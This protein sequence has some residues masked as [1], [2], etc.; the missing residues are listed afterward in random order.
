MEKDGT[1]PHGAA[2]GKR[3][4]STESESCHGKDTIVIG[5]NVA[6]HL[7]PNARTPRARRNLESV[8]AGNTDGHI[9]T[10]HLSS[11]VLRKIPHQGFSSGSV[12][13]TEC[14]FRGSPTKLHFTPPS[15][16]SPGVPVLIS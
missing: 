6:G 11:I 2:N 1:L 12:E 16:G 15:E 10:P 5:R 4:Q 14:S 3:K 8:A 9:F 7:N 13:V